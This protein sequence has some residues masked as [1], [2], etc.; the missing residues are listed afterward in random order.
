MTRALYRRY[1][2]RTLEDLLGQDTIAEVLRNA[3]K[4]NRLGHAYLFYGSR[5]TGKTTAA[6]L[7]AKIAN[8]E[9]RATDEKFRATGEPCNEC[10]PCKEIDAGHALDV[11]EIDAASNRGIDEMRDLK[12]GIRLSPT[13]YRYKV[14]IIDEAHQLTKEASNALLKTLEEPPAHAIFILATT[15]YDKL[16]PTITSRT[17]RFNF[18]RPA[19][20]II[21]QKLEKIAKEEKLTLDE[22]TLQLIARSADGSFRDAESLLEQVVSLNAK[23]VSEVEHILGKVGIERTAGFAEHL[24]TGN[25][26]AALSYLEEVHE[27]GLNIVQ[28]TKDIIHYLRRVLALKYDP[29]L[30]RIY[31]RELSEEEIKTLEK[32]AQMITD[33]RRM[34]D[35][36]KSLIQAYGDMKYSPFAIIPVQV[37]IIES[38]IE[39]K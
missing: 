26:S 8:C 14:F 17:Q 23:N 30:A 39:K 20:K 35:L 3:A 33:D 24:I 1:R 9:R 31:E 32:H 18:R 16:L 13:S 21:L 4:E 6:R 28:L 12:E 29:T 2:P 27:S 7:L 11:I 37:A 5:G 10:R 15:E 22:K 25:L 38:L 34:I 36:L 19:F